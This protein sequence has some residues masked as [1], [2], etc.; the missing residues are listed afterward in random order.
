[1]QILDKYIFQFETNTFCNLQKYN[2][3]SVTAGNVG[4]TNATAAAGALGLERVR[5]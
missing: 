3:L 2:L 4:S 5:L 1:M